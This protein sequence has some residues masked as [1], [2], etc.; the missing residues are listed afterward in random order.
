MSLGVLQAL[1]ASGLLSRVDYLS[2]VSGG[3]LIGASMSSLLNS[4]A[5]SAQPETFPLGF[6]AGKAERPAIRYL[7][8]HT[9]WLAPGGG[10][11]EVRLPAIILRGMLNNF[12]V[13]LP[14]LMI[15]VLLTEQFFQLAYRW[16]ID[17]VL[18]V[19]VAGRGL[20]PAGARAAGAVPP[21]RGTVPRIVDR[22][23][24]LRAPARVLARAR[25]H[26]LRPDAAVP[27]RAAGDRPRLGHG[28]GRLRRRIGGCSGPRPSRSRR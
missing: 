27:D 3:G 16:G 23:R 6:D 11:D 17:K 14:L 1:S 25:R 2:T 12:A 19:P 22:S 5:A 10:L 21:V 26:A 8:N 15:A 13:L 4:P 9:R 24:S 28:Q 20:R 7:R 18:F